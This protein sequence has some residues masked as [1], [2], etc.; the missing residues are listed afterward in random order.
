MRMSVSAG[1]LAADA[2]DPGRGPGWCRGTKPSS[3]KVPVNGARSPAASL[4]AASSTSRDAGQN[5][6]DA[7]PR[8]ARTGLAG[9]PKNAQAPCS[10]GR[11]WSKAR[12]GRPRILAGD[13]VTSV[14]GFLLAAGSYSTC[15]RA[16]ARVAA[17]G[18]RC[19]E[20]VKIGESSRYTAR[21]AA[22]GGCSECAGGA[23]G[24][25]GDT[26]RPD[27]HHRIPAGDRP[28]RAERLR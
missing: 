3:G 26:R 25:A 4:T 8:P 19:E 28:A 17:G 15:M 2:T 21:P 20:A 13:R 11:S 10:S 14:P 7:T 18:L 27:V 6:G 5:A 16:L 22:P 1:V 24:R 23:P 9:T 12:V